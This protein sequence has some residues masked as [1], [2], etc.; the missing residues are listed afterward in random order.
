MSKLFDMISAGDVAPEYYAH[1]WLARVAGSTSKENSGFRQ[2][3]MCDRKV[4][5]KI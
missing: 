1:G 2:T 3:L 4:A 5:E